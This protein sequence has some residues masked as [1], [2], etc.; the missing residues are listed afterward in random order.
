MVNT[1]V[2]LAEY[3]LF[4]PQRNGG[5]RLFKRT[6][7]LAN[8]R[9]VRPYFIFS[10]ILFFACIVVGAAAKEPMPWLDSALESLQRIARDAE[11]SSRPEQTLFSSILLNNVYS[12][13]M[14]MYMGIFAG[15]T[16]I[17]TL[18]VNG[19]LMGYLFAMRAAAG[20]SV[21][22]AIVKG[23]LPHGI[24]EI[25]ALLLACACGIR[26]GFSLVRGLWGALLGKE[27][28]WARFASALKGTVPAAV[29]IV[30]LLVIAAAV[31][32]TVTYWL[33]NA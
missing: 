5:Y 18:V 16:P 15:V 8:W 10:V 29:L 19:M 27:R 28:P 26:L 14:A 13:L 32:S 20:L 7:L 1:N 17:A 6:A 3:K 30:L 21:G 12:S 25:P 22:P 11:N 24:F 23:I 4:A 31:E 9:E 2:C 33:M